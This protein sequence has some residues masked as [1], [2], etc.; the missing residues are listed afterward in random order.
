MALSKKIKEAEG[1]KAPTAPS[2]ASA[3]SGGAKV[4]AVD[5]FREK[6]AAARAKMS[7]DEKALEGSKSDTLTF[8]GCIGDPIKQASL[9]LKD[10]TYTKTP[11]VVGYQFRSSED[12]QVP[13][14]PIKEGASDHMAVTPT[15]EMRAVKAGETF[16]LN[17]TETAILLSRV[18]Y[19][20][21]ASGE[22]TNAYLYAKPPAKDSDM[23]VTPAVRSALGTVK[24]NIE[25]YAD[26]SRAKDG[27]ITDKKVKPGFEQFAPLLE[28]KQRISKG[29]STSGDRQK[30][31]AAGFREMYKQMGYQ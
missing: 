5:V 7:D 23:P 14:C 4:S 11:L 3:K 27:T 18:E 6:G 29:G 1:A 28:R 15:G 2:T 30:A 26:V 9:K 16:N 10:G 31:V 25:L 22:G 24:N 13:V 17:V 21:L 8:V 20:T 12:I 19:S